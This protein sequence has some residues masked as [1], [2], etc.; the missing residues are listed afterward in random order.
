M[1]IRLSILIILIAIMLKNAIARLQ[2]MIIWY[3]R[4]YVNTLEITEKNIQQ[5]CLK[6]YTSTLVN[7]CLCVAHIRR[8][9]HTYIHCVS[10]RKARMYV[11]HTYIQ[12]SSEETGAYTC[13][14]RCLCHSKLL[15]PKQTSW[16]A[17]LLLEMYVYVYDVY[18]PYVHTYLGFVQG[19]GGGPQWQVSVI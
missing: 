10:R 6:Q 8:Y 14:Q 7:K 18:S 4:P 19:R 11:L 17:T 13:K 2:E 12:V 1:S 9:V 3:V 15:S 16:P 5:L